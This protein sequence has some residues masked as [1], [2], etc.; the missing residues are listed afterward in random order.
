MPETPPPHQ[1]R[2]LAA[3]ASDHPFKIG[4]WIGLALLL[5]VV[6]ANLVQAAGT[7]LTIVAA[8]GFF[9]IGFNPVVK[10]LMRRGMSRGLAVFLLF[11]GFVLLVCGFLA[12][13]I[14]VAV[15]QFGA[16]VDAIPGWIQQILSDPRFEE[17]TRNEDLIAKAEALITPANIS[18]VLG[19]L[20]GGATTV[21]AGV[22][23]FVT[24]FILMFFILAGF[25]RLRD[26]A[27]QLIPFSRR[28]RVGGIA[29]QILDK[30]G[31]Y[32]VGSLSIAFVAGTTALIYLWIISVPYALLLALVVA[33]CDLIPQVGATLGAIIVTLVAFGTR[34]LAV[35]IATIVFFVVYQ[36]LEN[37]LI[38]P[39]VM[40]QAVQI[41]N[42][43]AIVSVL[44]GFAM[45][46]VMGVFI[47]VP[48]YAALQLIIRQVVHP[49]QDSL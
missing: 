19:G 43:A 17:L 11:V 7:V 37:W 4:I 25:D 9:A 27:Y 14:P 48:G 10:W 35:A 20:V 18:L 28:E 5:V 2:P 32:L 36:Q 33:V 47:S 42:L 39:R 23:N 8:A 26:G 49:R 44:I 31:G 13:L 22:F 1:T 45:F 46:G 24:A 6:A 34:G 30:V 15:S 38:Y 12:L 3:S 29:D 41:S 16:L 40:R 21:A